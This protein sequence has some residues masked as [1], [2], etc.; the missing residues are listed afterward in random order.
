MIKNQSA[1][2]P[3]GGCP[4]AP[5]R[6]AGG[7]PR[8]SPVPLFAGGP[9]SHTGPLPKAQGRVAGVAEMKIRM[10]VGGRAHG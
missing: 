9:L 2:Q 1:R 10:G 7:V 4:R 3:E 6:A 5:A 8:K